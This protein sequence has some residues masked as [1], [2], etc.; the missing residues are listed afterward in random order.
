MD[1]VGVTENASRDG[2]SDS[3]SHSVVPVAITTNSTGRV[4]EH[5]DGVISGRHPFREILCKALHP[6]NGWGEY[7]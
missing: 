4:R 7:S 6:T 1:N 5:R 2:R 3:S